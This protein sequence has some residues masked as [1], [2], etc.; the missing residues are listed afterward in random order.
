[1]ALNETS[2][3]AELKQFSSMQIREIDALRNEITSLRRKD[4]PLLLS[5]TMP[6]RGV[7]RSS[8]A[9]NQQENGMFP[10]IPSA[11]HNSSR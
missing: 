6:N 7:A 8:S 11:R 3:R 4:A 5:S 10:P 9:K 2:D 1:M